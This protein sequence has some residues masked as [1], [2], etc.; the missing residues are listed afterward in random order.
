MFQ[1]Q[2]PESEANYRAT[3]T[4]AYHFLRSLG[5]TEFGPFTLFA[6][7]DLNQYRQAAMDYYQK[8]AWWVERRLNFGSDYAT[9]GPGVIWH[10][11]ATANY[12]NSLKHGWLDWGAGEYINGSF[13]QIAGIDDITS[14]EPQLPAWLIEGSERYFVARMLDDGTNG[15][16]AAVRAQNITEERRRP[17]HGGL[18]IVEN[19]GST[20]DYWTMGFWALEYLAEHY[21]GDSKVVAWHQAYKARLRSETWREAFQKVYGISIRDFNKEFDAYRLVH[22]PAVYTSGNVQGT[23]LT[24]NGNQADNIWTFACPEHPTF[25][26]VPESTAVGDNLGRFWDFVPMKYAETLQITVAFGRTAEP[27]SIFGYYA[28]EGVFTSDKAKA[29]IIS[30]SSTKSFDL[31]TLQFPV[32]IP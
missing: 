5:V 22:Y 8:P 27:A 13:L 6:F 26:C 23:L 28:G 3:I 21:G 10:W 20:G 12:Q 30:L 9:H 24:A 18:T 2:P 15:E 4:R 7:A 25:D 11:T 1:G 32:G 16:Y 14:P 19:F 17:S 31:G 29:A